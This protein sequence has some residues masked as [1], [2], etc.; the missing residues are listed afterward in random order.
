MRRFRCSDCSGDDK[1]CE[2]PIYGKVVHILTGFIDAKLF[3][4]CVGI[5]ERKPV[6]PPRLAKVWKRK[7]SQVRASRE[8]VYCWFYKCRAPLPCHRCHSTW[9]IRFQR[10]LGNGTPS[11]FLPRY[12]SALSND[13]PPAP[14]K[15]VPHNGAASMLAIISS[16]SWKRTKIEL[17]N[18]KNG[19]KSCV[20]IHVKVVLWP[21]GTRR[22][23]VLVPHDS[24]ALLN[25][26]RMEEKEREKEQRRQQLLEKQKEK[27]EFEQTLQGWE[28]SLLEQPIKDYMRTMWE[29]SQSSCFHALHN[30]HWFL[31]HSFTWFLS[32]GFLWFKQLDETLRCFVSRFLRSDTSSSCARCRWIWEKWCTGSW[33]DALLCQEKA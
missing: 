1:C 23:K 21:A 22:R 6:F 5:S 17:V 33:R 2:L 24:T 20:P 8:F 28:D 18:E 27:E 10:H 32:R 19:A 3:L 14:I 25:Q 29:V 15:H 31:D 26:L 9:I 30:S 13:T 16:I 11:P 7:S 12:S 4:F